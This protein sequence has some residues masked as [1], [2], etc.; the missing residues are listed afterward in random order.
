MKND[1]TITRNPGNSNSVSTEQQEFR[2]DTPKPTMESVIA[3]IC[4]DATDDPLSFLI[5][6]DT[7]H[8]GE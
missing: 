4:L 8:D 6:S 3:A 7:V 5:R 2:R 1:A